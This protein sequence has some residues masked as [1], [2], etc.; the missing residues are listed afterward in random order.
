MSSDSEYNHARSA[1]AVAS[2]RAKQGDALDLIDLAT[3]NRRFR[4][5]KAR[6]TLRRL[7][8]EVGEAVAIDAARELI[9][10]Y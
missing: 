7:A 5:A 2:K 6:M 9:A 3:A 4:E 8:G 1:L 10:A